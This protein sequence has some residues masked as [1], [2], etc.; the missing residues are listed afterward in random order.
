MLFLQFGW[1]FVY[2]NVLYTEY[3]VFVLGLILVVGWDVV[4]EWRMFLKL[5]AR[6]RL[7]FAVFII[8]YWYKY[9]RC[10]PRCK[11]NE[12]IP[13]QSWMLFSVYDIVHKPIA[14]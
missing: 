11:P 12:L 1:E 9:T 6:P 5:V 4:W 7:R 8:C 14:F 13:V 3:F 10:S 2:I